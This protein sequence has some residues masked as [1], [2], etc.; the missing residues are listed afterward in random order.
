MIR[1]IAFS[2]VLAMQF[3]KMVE[4]GVV[5]GCNPTTTPHFLPVDGRNT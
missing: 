2:L 1:A 4:W 3:L 5:V